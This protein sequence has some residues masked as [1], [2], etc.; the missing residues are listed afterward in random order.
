MTHPLRTA[1]IAGDLDAISDLLAPDIELH[2][3]ALRYP[4]RGRTAA[5]RVFAALRTEL[6]NLQLKHE[7]T[8][9]GA[10][11]LVLEGEIGKRRIEWVDVLEHDSAGLVNRLSVYSRPLSG[12]ALFGLAIGP[13]LTSSPGQSRAIRWASITLLKTL[14]A[15]E[16][17]TR[18]YV[19]Q[20]NRAN[21][22]AQEQ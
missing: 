5:C 11:V 6:H 4:I 16:R 9:D 8:G 20:I 19:A 10:T 14:H 22:P 15:V 12:P 1:F 13:H 21:T 18:G 3:P 2:G 17:A 7:L